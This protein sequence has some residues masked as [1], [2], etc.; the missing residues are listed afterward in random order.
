MP[1]TAQSP[2][3]TINEQNL[4]QY[5][6][7]SS[8][9]ILAIVGYATNGPMNTV[10]S[11]NS[12]TAFISTFGNPSTV[13]PWGAMAALRAL[14]QAGT[15]LYYRIANGS[16]GVSQG[17]STLKGSPAERVLST[18]YP[19]GV[20]AGLQ[21]GDSN[22]VLFQTKYYGTGNN[23]SYITITQRSNPV[24]GDSMYDL[25]YY[26]SG[27]SLLES[28][29]GINFRIGDSH[30]FPTVI[31]ATT[32]NGGSAYLNVGYAQHNPNSPVFRIAPPTGVG[33]VTTYYLGQAM[34]TLGDTTG[35]YY[36]AGLGDSWAMFKNLGPYNVR[37]GRDGVLG[38]T[39]SSVFNGDTLFTNALSTTGGGTSLSNAELF[40]YH[41]LSTPDNGDAAVQNSLL[42]LA[43]YRMD[44][45]ALIDPPFGYSVTNVINWH[46][47]VGGV[48][49]TTPLNSS[50]CATWWPWLLDFNQQNGQ[51]IWVPPSVFLGE[52]LIYTDNNY[53]PWYAP[54]GDI[55]GLLNAYN[56]EQSPSQADRDNLY[57]GLNAVN[58]IVNF[59]SKGLE[60]Y[61]QK[62]LSRTTSA[63]NR[64]NVRRMIIYIKKLIKNAINGLVFE[65][66]NADS[67]SR[68]RTIINS[69][70]EPVRQ[71]NGLA[72]YKVVI[73]STTNTPA[74]I[75]QSIMSGV[76]QIVPMG[77]IE[78]IQL[79]L[80]IDA[81]GSSIV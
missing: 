1:F 58:P 60:V 13:A 28:F 80:Q 46:N 79:V 31:G 20:T 61:G 27:G 57:G 65:P 39:A 74:L 4:S 45:L 37:F 35:R 59:A 5:T 63:I 69:I 56:Y 75:A 3:V 47:G 52:K 53:G 7:T 77:T 51:Y 23:G 43:E 62:T 81:V 32:V 71:A 76:I 48:G 68:A 50:Y 21:V 42:T 6:V 33:T 73:D 14:N 49:R 12:K 16:G 8:N 55:R 70:L 36:N 18:Q 40:N 25:K 19:F 72:D 64:I 22:K 38:G 29:L 2:S 34:S 26:S 41:I 11:I 15:V 24:T 66:N 17:D 30:F 67:W 54:A 78:M 10:T 44:F 9:T